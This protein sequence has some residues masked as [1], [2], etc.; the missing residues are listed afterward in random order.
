MRVELCSAALRPGTRHQ[1]ARAL[2]LPAAANA[3]RKGRAG[4]RQCWRSNA[5]A[6]SAGMARKVFCRTRPL[7]GKRFYTRIKLAG[8][9]TRTPGMSRCRVPRRRATAEMQERTRWLALLNAPL[10]LR[11]SGIQGR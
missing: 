7:R 2:A 8:R 5:W 6:D 4:G 11:L 9:Y 3:D 1:P 10:H